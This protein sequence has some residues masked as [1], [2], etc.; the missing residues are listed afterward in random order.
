LWVQCV[1][2]YTSPALASARVT[3]RSSRNRSGDIHMSDPRAVDIVQLSCR[4]RDTL[5]PRRLR[6]LAKD[7]LRLATEIENVEPRDLRSS[8]S[9]VSPTWPVPKSATLTRIV[10]LST[11]QLSALRSRC[12]CGRVYLLTF[13]IK[14]RVN[15]ACE[16]M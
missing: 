5:V 16:Q 8:M 7:E 9:S 4:L 2:L 12:T 3:R 6:A 15:V 10:L 11:K 13:M 1:Y 14:V